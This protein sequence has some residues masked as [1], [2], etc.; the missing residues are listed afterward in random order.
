[1]IYTNEVIS[2]IIELRTQKKTT[3]E[4]SETLGVT[5]WALEKRVTELKK[6]G[7]VFPPVRHGFFSQP[8][9]KKPV[10]K[11]P[12]RTIP[13]AIKPKPKAD[14]P[15]RKVNDELPNM[16]R[17]KGTQNMR[18]AEHSRVVEKVVRV[19]H[20]TFVIKHQKSA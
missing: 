15:K 8:I 6:K 2:L 18:I 4:I 13:P 12:K 5:Q 19:D 11:P 20:R 10:P 9:R 16:L 14:S 17:L 1:M 3:K 7:I